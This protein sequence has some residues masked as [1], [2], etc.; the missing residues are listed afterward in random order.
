MIR[1]V[2]NDTTCENLQKWQVFGNLGFQV[3]LKICQMKYSVASPNFQK[4]ANE[5]LGEYP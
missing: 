3:L 2:F 4:L 1:A 5:E